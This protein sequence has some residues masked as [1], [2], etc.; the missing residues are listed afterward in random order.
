MSDQRRVQRKRRAER[1]TDPFTS[2]SLLQIL[3][4]SKLLSGLVTCWGI[5]VLCHAVSKN[6]SG[7]MAVRFLLGLFESGVQPILVSNVP[8]WMSETSDQFIRRKTS[9][10]LSLFE[11]GAADD[12]DASFGSLPSFSP[13]D[14]HGHVLQAR[15]A[16]QDY[17]LLVWDA[18]CASE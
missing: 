11:I 17:L 6:W 9:S 14:A 12:S 5:L 8:R 13:D 10:R 4:I 7:L 1:V 18:S 2:S 15:G 16:P 3:P